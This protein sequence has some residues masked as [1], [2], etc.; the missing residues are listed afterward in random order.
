MHGGLMDDHAL[1]RVDRTLPWRA[2]EY[3][4]RVGVTGLPPRAD[5]VC[6]EVDVFRVVLAVDR[7]R[8]EAHDMH[9]RTAS[10][11]RELAHFVRVA[12][13]LRNPPGQLADDVA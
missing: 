13:A 3:P 8:H 7:R 1:G 6:G 10:P 4:L 9:C 2:L 5:A 11:R 12:S